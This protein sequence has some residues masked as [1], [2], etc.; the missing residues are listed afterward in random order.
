M[1]ELISEI[2]DREIGIELIG[3][4]GVTSHFG[5]LLRRAR[6]PSRIKRLYDNIID[7]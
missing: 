7:S 3:N 2:K 6:I 4:V 1:R 5:D